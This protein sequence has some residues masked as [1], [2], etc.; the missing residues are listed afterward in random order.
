MYVGVRG[1]WDGKCSR[2]FEQNV[3][4]Q[5]HHEYSS[6]IVSRLRIGLSQPILLTNM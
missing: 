2:D 6:Y 4:Y 3:C 1:V 5:A